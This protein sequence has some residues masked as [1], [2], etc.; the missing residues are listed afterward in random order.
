MTKNPTKINK[1]RLEGK[2]PSIIV[3]KMEIDIIL[4]IFF[5]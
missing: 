3:E 1:I 5:N 4:K 2:K